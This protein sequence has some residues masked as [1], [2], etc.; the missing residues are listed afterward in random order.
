MFTAPGLSSFVKK[1]HCVAEK[2]PNPVRYP[3]TIP[4]FEQLD[5]TNTHR[6]NKKKIT[7]Q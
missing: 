3:T 4:E 7:T 1:V 5:R 6:T 2:K